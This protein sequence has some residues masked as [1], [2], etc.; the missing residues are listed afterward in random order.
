MKMNC[1]ELLN[2]YQIKHYWLVIPQHLLHEKIGLIKK[3]VSKKKKKYLDKIF[4]INKTFAFS[5][6]PRPYWVKSIQS[7]EWHSFYDHIGNNIV[8]DN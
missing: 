1:W 6:F 8:V 4:R 7:V 5:T 3:V 2:S